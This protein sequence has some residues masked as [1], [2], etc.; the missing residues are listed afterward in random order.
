MYSFRLMVLLGKSSQMHIDTARLQQR[1]VFLV[2]PV[3][4]EVKTGLHLLV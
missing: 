1:C 2:F 4:V 3:S